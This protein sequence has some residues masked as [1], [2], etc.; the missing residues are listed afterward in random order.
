MHTLLCVLLVCCVL[1]GDLSLEYQH[2]W[3]PCNLK[4]AFIFFNL[5]DKVP[6][7]YPL[8]SLIGN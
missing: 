6:D 8:N 2:L 1:Q 7:A 5:S 4:V 3:N